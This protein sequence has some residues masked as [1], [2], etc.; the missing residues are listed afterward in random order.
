MVNRL[1]NKAFRQN[2]F[3]Q[4]VPGIFTVGSATIEEIKELEEL[5]AQLETLRTADEKVA[6][7]LKDK[8]QE[9]ICCK[10]RRT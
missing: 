7:T 1:Y 2:N 8:K 6:Q 5:K 3:Q 10:R 9:K 4:T